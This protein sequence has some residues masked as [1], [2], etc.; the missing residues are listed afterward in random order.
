MLDNDIENLKYDD[1]ESVAQL[2]ASERYLTI[3]AA[4]HDALGGVGGEGGG[5]PDSS[6]PP[7]VQW[8]GPTEEDPTYKLLVDCN[9]LAV[10]IDNEI[11]IIYNFIRDKYR[12]KF[13]ELESLVKSPLDYARVVAAIGNEQDVTMVDL[14]RLLPPA[15][16]MVVTVTATTTS[17][18]PLTEENLQ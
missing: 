2:A 6:V 14:D 3:I 16:V 12:T 7:A 5:G 1:L 10:D 4:V 11:V 15:Q 9:Q 17:G 13:P 18:K 8:T